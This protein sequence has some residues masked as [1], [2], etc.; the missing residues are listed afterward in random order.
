MSPPTKVQLPAGFMSLELNQSLEHWL[1][2][3]GIWNTQPSSE[4]LRDFTSQTPQGVHLDFFF[5]FLLHVGHTGGLLNRV[6]KSNPTIP[7]VCVWEAAEEM[8]L[9]GEAVVFHLL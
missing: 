1:L 7:H 6:H 8:V 5:F 2:T 9:V 3:G 4:V